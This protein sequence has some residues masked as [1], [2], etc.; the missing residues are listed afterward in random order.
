MAGGKR[1]GPNGSK[2][3]D[4]VAVKAPPSSG[5]KRKKK[6]NEWPWW[7]WAIGGFA[8]IVCVGQVLTPKDAHSKTSR[9]SKGKGGPSTERFL[10]LAL[11]LQEMTEIASQLNAAEAL[12]GEAAQELN[13]ELTGIEEELDGAGG[14]VARDLMS[15]VSV[16]RG[17]MYQK[18]ENLTDEQVQELNKSFTYANP[19]YWDDYYNK[20]SE[21]ERF[22]WYGSWDTAVQEVT[23]SDSGDEQKSATKRVGDI[24]RPYVAAE[25]RILMLGCGNSD[26][27]EKMYRQGF[28]D[29]MNVDISENLLEKLRQKLGAAAPRMRWQYA[30]ASSLDFPERAFDVTIDKGT[31]DAIEQNKPLVALAFQE[32]H[33][34]LRSGGYLLSV[35]FNPPS[36]RVEKQ[37]RENNDWGDCHSKMFERPEHKQR[38]YVHA[39]QRK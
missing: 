34:T 39:C 2:K 37:L 18:A 24:L 1:S 31:F 35:T 6:N 23:I 14:S 13:K 12:D 10:E 38:Y 8:V 20:T 30:N 5:S 28:E 27:S 16:V 26:M 33:R 29:I 22:D 11:R 21:E 19:N 4:D 7:M 9:G 36:L 17:Q 32:V 25:S 15:M 3:L